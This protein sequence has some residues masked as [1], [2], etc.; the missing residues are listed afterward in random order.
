MLPVFSAR[1]ALLG[2]LA[3]AV[4][5]VVCLALAVMSYAAALS[6]RR[7]AAAVDELR[8]AA[9]R[10]AAADELADYGVEPE[11]ALLADEIEVL[12]RDHSSAL[13]LMG[14]RDAA[15]AEHVI[16]EILGCG[17]GLVGQGPA[18][19]HSHAHGEIDGFLD[20]A[21]A[22]ARD[23]AT[24]A[25]RRAGVAITVAALAGLLTALLLVRSRLSEVGL[26]AALQERSSVDPLT[27]LANRRTL[28]HRLDAL[29]ASSGLSAMVLLD[30]DGFSTVNDELGHQVGDEILRAVAAR[31]G[32]IVRAGDLLA[33]IGGDEFG[34]VLAGLREPNEAL[35]I[36]ERCVSA[37]DESI[38]LSSGEEFIRVSGGVA[39]LDADVG[40]NRALVEADLAMYEAK[41][42]GGQ[43][44]VVFSP[45]IEAS[46]SRTAEITRA[47]RGLDVTRELSLVFQP[48]VRSDDRA[49][50]S[51][52]ALVRWES[53]TLGTVSP[54]DFIPLAERTGDVQ[55]IGRWVREELCRRLVDWD[56]QGRAVDV[57]M[58]MSPLELRG[59]DA[60]EELVSLVRSHGLSPRRFT[61]EI[62]E[63]AVID[64][65]GVMRRRLVELRGAGFRLAIDDFGSGYS[66]LGQLLGA[67]FDVLKVDRSL[68]LQLSEM[69]EAHGGDPSGPCAVMQSIA[70]IAAVFDAD[71][72]C[73]GVETAQQLTS[74]AASGVTFVQGYHTGRPAPEPVEV[75]SV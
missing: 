5:V 31:L 69:R 74:L 72:V 28:R 43:Q 63:S 10:V 53:P 62:T 32:E 45:E 4:L 75:V 19:D 57:S 68:L 71:I 56:A 58:N 51:H 7:D 11:P 48:I 40:A 25:E 66:N 55:V 33:R 36:A 13:S 12:A 47:L 39:V 14:P 15:R 38:W 50:V 24:R 1:R 29:D 49:V 3:L 61:V 2:T 21:S 67:P 44:A 60:V 8:L 27:G 26:E 16:D 17:L 20:R 46:A 42:L 35:E 18:V 9:N 73:E 65:A 52:E 23:A 54:A 30:L 37:F 22:A 70:G 41:R 6:S 64:D 34:L 59:D